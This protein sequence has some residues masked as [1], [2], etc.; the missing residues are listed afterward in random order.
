VFQTVYKKSRA[1]LRDYPGAAK[2]LVGVPQMIKIKF[3]QGIGSDT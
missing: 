2:Q 1:D 3:N